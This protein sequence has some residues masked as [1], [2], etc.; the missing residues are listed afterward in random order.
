M[1]KIDLSPELNIFRAFLLNGIPII[2]YLVAGM[3]SIFN[4]K[5][6]SSPYLYGLLWSIGII[7]LELYCLRNVLRVIFDLIRNNT[8]S[9]SGNIIGSKYLASRSPFPMVHF[10]IGDKKFKYLDSSVSKNYKLI[11]N[12]KG[13]WKLKYYSSSGIPIELS[14]AK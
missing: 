13:R 10:R 7:F 5:I 14:P 2:I 3:P 9:I 1:K 12:H 11:T 8:E 6:P 4:G